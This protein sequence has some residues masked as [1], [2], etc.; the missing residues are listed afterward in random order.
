MPGDGDAVC[1]N[2][3]VSVYEPS[4]ESSGPQV[5]VLLRGRDPDI[6]HP[7]P[8]FVQ[9]L[10]HRVHSGVVRSD[11][12]ARIHGDAVLLEHSS[13]ARYGNRP[14]LQLNARNSS[15]TLPGQRW[16]HSAEGAGGGGF[17]W[18][19]K[20]T[21]VGASHMRDNRQMSVAMQR[22]VD[23]IFMATNSTLLRNNT[24][25]LLLAGFSV[26]R[27]ICNSPLLCNG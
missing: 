25:T 8:G 23:F 9:Q 21:C 11:G 19:Q 16:R 26:G 3:N 5:G 24:V 18:L 10:V 17:K 6:P 4:S 7:L 15:V 2:H 1:T 20:Y 27:S 13:N 12:I 22:L 14:A